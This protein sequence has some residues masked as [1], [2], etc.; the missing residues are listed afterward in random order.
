MKLNRH[1]LALVSTFWY[2]ENVGLWEHTC[3]S[4][5]ARQGHPVTLFS[6]DDSIT[7]PAGVD[8]ADA[9]NILPEQ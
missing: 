3:L 5:F 7:L 2:G 1:A 9:S 4:S 6:Y 8:L